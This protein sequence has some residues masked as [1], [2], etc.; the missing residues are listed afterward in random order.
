MRCDCRSLAKL[1]RARAFVRA[2]PLAICTSIGSSKT[3]AELGYCTKLNV[4]W[5]FLT[6][7]HAEGRK[8]A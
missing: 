4:N 8:S 6:T 1:K 3:M 2:R 5:C 7:L